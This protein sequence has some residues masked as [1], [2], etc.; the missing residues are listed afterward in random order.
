ML[1]IATKEKYS[2]Y[3]SCSSVSNFLGFLGQQEH[4][5]W[6]PM[7]DGRAPKSGCAAVL[8]RGSGAFLRG[9]IATPEVLFADVGD[10]KSCRLGS[11]DRDVSIDE[12]LVMLEALD[13]MFDDAYE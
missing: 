11:R 5:Q 6:L 10:A 8:L 12:I 9:S 1:R 7:R 3:L 4:I 2:A 13:S